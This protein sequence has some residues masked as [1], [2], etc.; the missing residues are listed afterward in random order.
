MDEPAVFGIWT[1][2]K[3]CDVDSNILGITVFSSS[4]LNYQ[5]KLVVAR[6]DFRAAL[7]VLGGI[8]LAREPSHAL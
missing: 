4:H 5:A 6:A 1:K 3:L 2:M 8:S 7:P